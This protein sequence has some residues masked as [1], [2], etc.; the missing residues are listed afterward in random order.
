MN[1]NK[2]MLIAMAAGVALGGCKTAEQKVME[3]GHKPVTHAELQK[4][5]SR[6]RMVDWSSP[7]GSGTASYMADGT[8]S[9]NWGSGSDTGKWWIADG[10]FCQKW[11]NVRGGSE[12]CYMTYRIGENR[13]ERF[14][15]QGSLNSRFAFT[16]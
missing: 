15:E 7:N 14:T 3:S 6:D 2:F 12:N 16:N 13:Y 9:V 4:E 11:M 5:Y 1:T 10:K 8:A